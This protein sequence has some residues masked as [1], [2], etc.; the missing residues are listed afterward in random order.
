MWCVQGFKTV[1]VDAKEVGTTGHANRGIQLQC[2]LDTCLCVMGF[3][4]QWTILWKISLFMTD[5]PISTGKYSIQM[6]TFL[7]LAPS[8]RNSFFTCPEDLNLI[9]WFLSSPLKLLYCIEHA[10]AHWLISKIGQF[11]KVV[12]FLN[13]LGLD[14]EQF[15]SSDWYR[16]G[17]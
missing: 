5:Q 3:Y 11:T 10:S 8:G 14:S 16:S 15:S 12:F 17:K 1:K 4:P 9:V 6:L 7:V 2:M 13:L